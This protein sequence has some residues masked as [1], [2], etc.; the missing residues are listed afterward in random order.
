MHRYDIC[1]A[2]GKQMIITREHDGRIVALVILDLAR[3]LKNQMQN[4]TIDLILNGEAGATYRFGSG[5]QPSVSLEMAF[6]DFNLLASGRIK[7]EETARRTIVT[8]DQTEAN[9]FLNQVAIPY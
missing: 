9:W 7:A 3:K 6:F 8:G 4:R 1:A 2:T 5:A